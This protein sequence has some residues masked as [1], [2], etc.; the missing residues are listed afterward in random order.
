MNDD[1][2]FQVDPFEPPAPEEVVSSTLE[3]RAEPNNCSMQVSFVL[4]EKEY[5]ELKR[6][7]QDSGKRM[8][9]IVAGIVKDF[10]KRSLIRQRI[11]KK[12]T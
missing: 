11:L 3:T 8:Q 12:N 2:W 10:V 5:G 4:T 7:E 9:S 6:I 1:K